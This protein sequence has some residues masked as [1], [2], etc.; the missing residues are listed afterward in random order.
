MKNDQGSCQS[1]PSKVNSQE[2][3]R[4]VSFNGKVRVREHLHKGDMSK[5]ELRSTWYSNEELFLRKKQLQ[6]RKLRKIASSLLS[7]EDPFTFASMKNHLFQLSDD[8]QQ[9]TAQLKSRRIQQQ[10]IDLGF[11][12][13]K[14][15]A[16]SPASFDV[17]DRKG[18][19]KEETTR[20]V[21]GRDDP[22]SGT[23]NL[24]CRK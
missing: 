23:G 1:L 8:P 4:Q 20:V 22:S 3:P 16:S 14:P 17:R 21:T 12:I 13:P 24:S 19:S 2:L 11:V 15:P 7:R 5:S 6:E 10:L 9:L 18:H